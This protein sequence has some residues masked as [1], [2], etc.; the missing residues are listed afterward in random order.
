MIVGVHPL[1]G[2]DKVLHYTVPEALRAD[3]VPGVLVRVPVSHRLHLGIV[4]EIGPL[5]R[6]IPAPDV[7]MPMEK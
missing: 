4:G 3:V 5:N 1:A 6:M 7:S 2:F